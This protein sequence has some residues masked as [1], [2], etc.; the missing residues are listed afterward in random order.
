[1]LKPFRIRALATALAAALGVSGCATPYVVKLPEPKVAPSA[2]SIEQALGYLND[3]RKVYRNAVE[4]QVNDEQ[5]ASNALVGA[6]ALIA[7]LAL[8]QVHRDGV[9]GVAT[10][11]GTGYALTNNNLPRARLQVH[12]E[13]LKALNCAER[14]ALPLAISDT[15]NT[16]LSKAVEEL[17]GGRLLLQ[18][19]L[20]KARVVRDSA[21]GTDQWRK[22]FP[23]AEAAVNEIL[24]QTA[25]SVTAAEAFQSASDRAAI[26]LVSW[27]NTVRDNSISSLA[28]ARSPLAEVPR[29]VLG[30]AKDMGTFAPGAGVDSLIAG[31]LKNATP[32]SI[33]MTGVGSKSDL[34]TALDDLDKVARNT[35]ALQAPVNA[36][37]R[38]RNTTFADDA[39][40]DCNVAQVVTALAVTPTPLKFSAQDGGQR[41]L[42]L[43]GG[44]KPYFL[45]LDG[46]PVAGLSYPT[47][48]IR[49]GEA[50]ISLKA[51]AVT[52]GVKTGLRASDSSAAGQG[53]RIE[54]EIV[55]PAAAASAPAAAASAAVVTPPKPAQPKAKAPTAPPTSVDAALAALKKVG[56]FASSGVTFERKGLP[57]KVGDRIE[58]TVICPATGTTVFK[59]AELAKS[60]LSTVGIMDFPVDKVSLLTEPPTCAP[61]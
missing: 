12:V 47:G 61:S 1:M 30:L 54:I 8:G 53:V 17:K 55:A 18:A 9:L 35:V 28:D 50:E 58:I 19:E 40:K 49:G 24:T 37:L 42:E 60:Y 16:G 11:A 7:A 14:A 4:A 43:K 48:P 44:V 52:S 36:A 5:V 6:G 41:V 22:A 59:R 3:T 26:S 46:G 21:L 25:Q 45:Q 31:A 33:S 38:G 34:E 20:R 51:G 29:L 27:V 10:I 13:A 32:A 2:R 39:F 56:K 23:E 57:V 15:E